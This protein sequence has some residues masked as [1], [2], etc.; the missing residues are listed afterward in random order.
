MSKFK[1]RIN[2]III[3]L[4]LI[5][6]TIQYFELFS[7]ENLNQNIHLI[8]EFIKAYPLWTIFILL[9][10]SI[11]A[12]NSPLPLASPFYLMIGYFFG[13][14][15]G[16]IL[17]L[18]TTLFGSFIGFW[19]SKTIF[20]HSFHDKHKEL[21]KKLKPDVEEQGYYYFTSARVIQVM[22]YFLI[23]SFAGIFRIPNR[24]FAITTIVGNIPNAIIY[25]YLGSNL[26]SFYDLY[27]QVDVKILIL[28]FIIG[29]IFL[30]PIF[31]KKRKNMRKNSKKVKLA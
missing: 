31:L 7:A 15:Y 17:I 21:F 11:I 4:I 5:I 9:F 28:L 1:F 13:V 30:I 18:L 25:S 26:T 16:T 23:N 22:P 10:L 29:L 14:G 3:I 24:M 12:M 27:N 19:C 8:Q 20:Y 2:S 6:F